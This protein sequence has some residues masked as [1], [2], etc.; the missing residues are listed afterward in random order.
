MS[1]TPDDTDSPEPAADEDEFY[2]IAYHGG[3]YIIVRLAD[4]T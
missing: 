1:T 2:D 3:A 4:E